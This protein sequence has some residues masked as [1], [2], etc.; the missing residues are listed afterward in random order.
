[1]LAKS[2]S[3]LAIISSDSATSLS[4]CT[5]FLDIAL[6]TY[7][8]E[9]SLSIRL[10]IT[11]LMSLIF[12]YCS[13]HDA[14]NYFIYFQLC[15]LYFCV[16]SNLLHSNKPLACKLSSLMVAKLSQRVLLLDMFI[17]TC[18]GLQA[19]GSSNFVYWSRLLILLCSNNNSS[20][21]YTICTPPD[22]LL[23]GIWDLSC[24]NF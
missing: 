19:K 21:Q 1:M 17:I 9:E 20:A 5:S 23:Q 2:N 8:S 15:S 24:S 11:F 6:S 18:L 4:R 12:F 22:H 13:V 3:I 16:S 10:M 14:R 7:S